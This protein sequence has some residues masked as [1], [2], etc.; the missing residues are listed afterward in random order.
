MSIARIGIGLVGCGLMGYRHAMALRGVRGVR[1]VALADIDPCAAARLAATLDVEIVA[2]A[3]ALVARPDIDA[4]V[5]ATSDDHH[6]E[7]LLA[8]LT[9]GKPVLVEK[10][11]TTSLAEAREIMA[12]AQAR[13]G[14]VIL[15]GQ[16][17]RHDP[18]FAGAAERIRGGAIGAVSHLVFRRNSSV[19]GPQ[20]YGDRARLA[21]HVLAHDVDLL[22]FMTGLAVERVYAQ[23]VPRDG[24]PTAL[25]ALLTLEGGA[26]CSLEACWGLP[27]APGAMLDGA[28]EI[29]GTTGAIKVETLEQGLAVFDAEGIH[30]P[31]TMRYWERDGTGGGLVRIQAEHFIACIDRGLEPRATLSDGYEVVRICAAIEASLARGAPVSVTEMDA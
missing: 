12:A 24:S 31:D 13:P 16:L 6:R 14:P 18:R 10:P 25:L 26:L 15:V 21:F 30:H 3:A 8:A 5:I 1:I 17:L 23:A 29:I 28:A 19:L 27:P 20:R 4:V 22:R 9:A 11:L 2:D 7:P